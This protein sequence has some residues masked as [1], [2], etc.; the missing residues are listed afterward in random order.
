MSY[1]IVEM[2]LDN[3]PANRTEGFV[4]VA[5]AE[6]ANDSGYGFPGVALIAERARCCER[7]T[8]RLIKKMTMDGWVVSLPRAEGF[9]RKQNAY[10][11][12]LT[13]LASNVSRA[14]QIADERD[15]RSQRRQLREYSHGP[16]IADET[17]SDILRLSQV[18]FH[19]VSGDISPR[20][21]LKNHE[22]SIEPSRSVALELLL[23]IG[24]EGIQTP[25][26][27]PLRA[28][29]DVQGFILPDWIER[30]AWDGYEEMRNKQRKPMTTRA[31]T[32]VIA[33][34]TVLRED[35]HSPNAA[36]NQSTM[37]NWVDVYPAKERV[38]IL[39]SITSATRPG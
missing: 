30:E 28:K 5:I 29:L 37:R 38:R 16:R 33:H 18:T 39:Q 36:L 19:P 23:A 31:K 15:K 32:M 35:G 11:L 6:N 25:V 21:I 3:G 14:T 27:M 20:P 13:K 2:V 12:N 34:L 9:G 22:P 7:H 10:Q 1:K 4:L 26:A 17:S 24:A 8:L